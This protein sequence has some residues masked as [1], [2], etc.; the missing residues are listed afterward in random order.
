MD[1]KMVKKYIKP[2][3][4]VKEALTLDTLLYEY[5][6]D[7]MKFSLKEIEIETRIPCRFI[8]YILR[9]IKIVTGLSPLERLNMYCPS[10]YEG[11]YRLNREYYEHCYRGPPKIYKPSK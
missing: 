9:G 8:R 1:N 2:I 11:Y 4:V 7:K 5:G 6:K 10:S 3:Q